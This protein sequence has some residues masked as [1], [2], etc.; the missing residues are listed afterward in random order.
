MRT[1]V[2][3]DLDGTLVD[4]SADLIAAANAVLSDDGFSERLC[5]EMDAETAFLGGRA[6]LALAAR[7]AGLSPAEVTAVAEAGYARLL[8]AYAANIDHHSRPYP[9]AERVVAELA[10]SG[11]AI[12][13]CTNKPESLADLLLTRLGWRDAFSALIGADTLEVRKPDPAPLLTAIALA[14]GSV[15][16]AVLIG[17][18]ETDHKTGLAAGIPVILADFGPGA[19][20]ARGLGAAALFPN[21]NA[22]PEIITRVLD[23]G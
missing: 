20:V 12:G 16:R 1:T 9:D 5:P 4:T 8:D 3:F 2:I 7:R 11:A 22:L 13:I 21:F 19:A 14:G 23:G 10:A 15:E 18:T 17:D 6:M